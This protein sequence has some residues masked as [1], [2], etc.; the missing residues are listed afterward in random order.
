[1]CQLSG[2]VE[3]VATGAQPVGSVSSIRC[4]PSSQPDRIGL[5]LDTPVLPNPPGPEAYPIPLISRRGKALRPIRTAEASVVESD[6][7]PDFDVYASPG[8][9]IDRES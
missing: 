5:D 2:W 6:A 3:G 1:M 9:P 8:G 7:G 4:R